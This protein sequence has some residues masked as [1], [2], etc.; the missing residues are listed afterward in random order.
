MRR[1]NY[2]TVKTAVG[3]TAI[4]NK[5]KCFS[6][7]KY[8]CAL[9]FK[10]IDNAVIDPTTLIVDIDPDT[11]EPFVNPSKPEHFKNYNDV[12]R[13]DKTQLLKLQE[14]CSFNIKSP[15]TRRIFDSRQLIVDR[16]LQREIDRFVS[17]ELYKNPSLR[18]E[19]FTRFHIVGDLYFEIRTQESPLASH[20]THYLFPVNNY[21]RIHDIFFFISDQM[22]AEIVRSV[23][24]LADIKKNI[25]RI[26]PGPTG[27]KFLDCIIKCEQA[28]SAQPRL[29]ASPFGSF[30]SSNSAQISSE[31]APTADTIGSALRPLR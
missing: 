31:S 11:N 20:E 24:N 4:L 15:S 14:F 28:A 26:I 12:P 10:V 27:E 30:G 2:K 22:M 25:T 3:N 8:C 7:E 18:L 23:G 16:K 6:P 13:Y 29:S 19:D 9:T 5:I 17:T 21:R 1:L